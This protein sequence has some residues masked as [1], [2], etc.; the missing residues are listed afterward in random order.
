ME[1]IQTAAP[2][3]WEALPIA[4][5]YTP[6]VLPAAW[7]D[8]TPKGFAP[9]GKAFASTGG[10]RVI[11]SVEH[12]SGEDRWLHVSV[13][14][15]H[16]IPSWEDLGLVKDLFIGRDRA[17]VQILP[18]ANEYVNFHKYTLHLWSNLEKERFVP[19]FRR[20]GIL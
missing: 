13:S 15:E 14:R 16:S 12:R 4:E 10:L 8:V 6:F 20:K 2:N 18:K 5:M 9:F 17:A 1:A 11:L 3:D 7:Y 19:D